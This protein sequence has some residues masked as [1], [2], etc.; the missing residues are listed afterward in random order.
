MDDYLFRTRIL[1]KNQL[2]TAYNLPLLYRT[3]YRNISMKLQ[4]IVCKFI[5]FT[6]T[7][8][9]FNAP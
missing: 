7:V 3:R 2:K 6:T 9:K 4:L 1:A 5:K 8:E